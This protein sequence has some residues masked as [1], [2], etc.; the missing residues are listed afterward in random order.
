LANT[1][2]TTVLYHE[3]RDNTEDVTPAKA[4]RSELLTNVPNR[5]R[6]LR[7]SIFGCRNYPLNSNSVPDRSP[8]G[9]RQ[10]VV[11]PRCVFRSDEDYILPLNF[12][13]GGQHNLVEQFGERNFYFVGIY[14]TK[15]DVER[16]RA[17]LEV[18]N[19]L[20]WLSNWRLRDHGYLRLMPNN[21]V[22]YVTKA[23][24]KPIWYQ[25]LVPY[26]VE[27]LEGER[28]W[29]RVT[30]TSRWR[31]EWGREVTDSTTLNVLTVCFG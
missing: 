9:N 7:F 4:V 8:L 11:S 12:N 22:Q 13:E 27:V 6:E 16:K 5:L 15:E 3:F 31:P 20:G 18:E 17:R 25:I 30:D 1:S 26:T 19:L 14:I 28:T 10:I 24:H 23:L 21:S 2:T 29:N